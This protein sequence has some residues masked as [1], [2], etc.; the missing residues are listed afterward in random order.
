[1]GL[2]FKLVSVVN[3]FG[4]YL[5]PFDNALWSICAVLQF[6]IA[7][8]ILTRFLRSVESTSTL[9]R[10]GWSGGGTFLSNYSRSE[11]LCDVS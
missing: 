7:P 6:I 4:L 5:S 3:K 9:L 1:M 10:V 8:S 2:I 11:L